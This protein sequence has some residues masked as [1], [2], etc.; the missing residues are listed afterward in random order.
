[1]LAIV[2]TKPATAVI[3]R[4]IGHWEAIRGTEPLPHRALLDPLDIAPLLPNSELIDVIDGGADFRYRLIGDEIDRIS[5][6][7]YTGKRLSEIPTQRPPSQIY[8]LYRET[9]RRRLP[10]TV[11]LPY[12]GPSKLIQDVEVATLPL[13]TDDSAVGV[14]WGVVVPIE[15]P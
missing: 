2:E 5:L 15:V 10:V 12:V 7:R 13:S 14:L 3:R 9:V 4:A 6:A 11:R 8:A 1:M